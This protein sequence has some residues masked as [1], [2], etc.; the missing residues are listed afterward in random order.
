[1]NIKQRVGEL[2]IYLF[3]LFNLEL[4]FLKP[5]RLSS[6]MDS[7]L[8][9]WTSNNNVDIKTVIDIGASDGQW[10]RKAQKYL[11]EAYYL[12]IEANRFHEGKLHQ[13]KAKTKNVDYILAAASNCGGEIYFDARD[14]WGGL[15][16][17][18]KTSDQLISV[19]ATTIDDQVK[20][21]NLTPPFLLKFD[22]HG[23]EVPILEGA[24]E[25][26]K[27]TNLIIIEVYN[28]KLTPSSLRFWEICQ[29]LEKFGFRPVDVCE[30]MHRP[31]DG[32]LWQMDLVFARSSLPEF[33]S[34]NYS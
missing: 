13:Y 16:S 23:F 9:R 10:T 28:F 5:Y 2:L 32:I 30:P 20:Q 26:L 25:T 3:G 19:P 24:G 34:N 29:Y 12:L 4:R 11:P 33:N 7:A 18:K 17:E 31:R 15:A 8:A 6:S 21:K 27:N 22:T 14:P 1:M